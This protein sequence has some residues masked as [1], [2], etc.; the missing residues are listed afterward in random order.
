MLTCECAPG[1][2]CSRYDFTNSCKSFGGAH[3]TVTELRVTR[4]ASVSGCGG[5]PSQRTPL[6]GNEAALSAPLALMARTT[7]R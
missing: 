4:S 5:V 3:V 6:D 2:I 1:S 7:K